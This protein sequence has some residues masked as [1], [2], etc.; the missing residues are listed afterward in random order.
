MPFH[1]CS[2]PWEVRDMQDGT[3]VTLTARDLD[4]ET[5]PVLVDDLYELVSE[6][7]QPNLYLDLAGIHQL[8]SVVLGKMLALDTRLRQHGGRLVLL[9]LDPFVY[10]QFQLTRIIDVLDIRQAETAGSL[11]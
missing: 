8:A 9:N 11:A 3:L 6:S 4:K 5:V 7:G 1:F 2:H 10:Q